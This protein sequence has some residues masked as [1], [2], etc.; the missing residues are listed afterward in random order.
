LFVFADRENYVLAYDIIIK[1]HLC[2]VCTD[3][4]IFPWTEISLYISVML[5]TRGLNGIK[6]PVLNKMRIYVRGP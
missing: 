5:Y 1:Y 2:E 4:N 3:Y 6:W